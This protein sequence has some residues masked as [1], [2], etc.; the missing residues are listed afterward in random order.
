MRIAYLIV[1]IAALSAG[2]A[3][4][5]FLFDWTAVQPHKVQLL[6]PTGD[7]LTGSG[8]DITAVW[9]GANSHEYLRL[10]LDVQPTQFN[11]GDIYGVYVD[12]DPLASG[13]P[14][15]WL[16]T[17]LNS[18]GIDFAVIIDFAND[19]L[20]PHLLQWNTGT[21]TWDDL[22]GVTFTR[23]AVGG[24]YGLEWRFAQGYLPSVIEPGWHPVSFWGGV[25]VSGGPTL[26]L[27]EE[28]TTPEPTT[29]ALL[30]LGLGGMYLRRR[31]RS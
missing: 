23:E 22:G 11:H 13:S 25:N 8:S 17:E 30:G 19:F 27:T 1:L 9:W 12:I 3:N 31:R 24:D 2:A 15:S 26:D 16:P 5:A 29:L 10:D 4:A 7:Q 28:A 21:L 6:D 14:A 18:E 20:S